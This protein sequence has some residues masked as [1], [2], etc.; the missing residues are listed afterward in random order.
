MKAPPR[1]RRDR[2][3]LRRRVLPAYRCGQNGSKSGSH[4]NPGRCLGFCAPRLPEIQTKL[5]SCSTAPEVL[6]PHSDII[7]L[8]SN[9]SRCRDGGLKWRVFRFHPEV[10]KN[11]RSSQ[12]H[13]SASRPGERL[14]DSFSHSLLLSFV[15]SP[16]FF[17][18]I[19]PH[20]HTDVPF[21]TIPRSRQSGI[22]PCRA[23]I[24]SRPL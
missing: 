4:I 9:P 22:F 18:H 20:K 3:Q 8:R 21:S 2:P 14:R 1:I 17:T 23:Q 24:Q 10:P 16:F 12:Y 19:Y 11:L 15:F 5:P 6:L 13:R 7:F